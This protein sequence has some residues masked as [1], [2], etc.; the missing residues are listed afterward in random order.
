LF[1]SLVFICIPLISTA[2]AQVS[3]GLVIFTAVDETGVIIPGVQITVTEPGANAVE[4]WTDFAGRCTYRIL[5]RS[6]YRIHAEKAG[7][8]QAD[9]SNI[10]PA[11]SVVRITLAHQQVVREQVDVVASPP[12]IDP[13]Q[14][15]NTMT[16][17]TPEIVNIPYPTSRDIRNLLP[18][19]PGVVQDETGQVHV[20]GSE[21]WQTLDT[22]DGFDIR[23]PVSG[24]LALRVSSDAVRAIDQMSTRYPVEFGRSTGGVV[25]FYTGMGDNKFRFNATNFIPSFRNI[26]GI[27]FDKFVP[28]FT[29]SG[30]I[31]R[32]RVWWYDGLELEYSNI[33]IHELPKGEN[34]N[35]LSRG[36]N[37]VKV[38]ANLKPDN[39]L[40][41][42]YLFNA[43]RSP[44]DGIS[45][46]VPRVSTTKR[47][48]VAWL[49]Y[50][51][52]QWSFHRGSLLDV[53]VDEVRI[54]D[55]YMPR[56]NTPYQITPEISKGSYF[57]NLAGHSARQETTAAL[58]LSP[59]YLAGQ[60]DLRIGVDVDRVSFE[61]KLSRAPVSYLR[62]DGTLIRQSTFAAV[63]PY[64]LHNDEVGAYLQDR[65]KPRNNWLFEPGLRFDWDSLV[66]R[67]L[68]APRLAAIWTPQ[69]GSST[70]VSAGIGIYYD[71]TQLQYL[72]QSLTGARSDTYYAMNGLTPLGPAQQ[73]SFTADR[74]TLQDP[75]AVNWSVAIERK[76]P[77]SLFGGAS[78]IQKQ[79]SHQFTYV[80]QSGPVVFSG[81]Y[82]LANLSL[83][84]YH[85][86]QFNLRRVFADGYSLFFAY[87]HSSAMTNAALQY[88]PTPSPLGPQQSGPLP[89]DVPNR[90]I[91]WG[92]LP[93][94]LPFLKKSWDFVY[95]L[96]W[97]SGMPY[98]AVDA[99]QHVVGSAGA[100]R[101]PTTIDFSPGVEWRFHFWG[102]YYGLRGVME[103]ALDR[104]NPLVVNNVVDSPAFGTFS[105]PEGRAFTARI[106]IIASK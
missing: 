15:P 98:T 91:S 51:R 30:P 56:G 70:K 37:L 42:G 92:W 62:E 67:P 89:W 2:K 58:Y 10:E 40:K 79:T 21:T 5:G 87:T 8:Y 68:F 35:Q 43:L 96:D 39:I 88:W 60:H 54:R 65:W 24:M 32:D 57:E 36:S 84:G 77:W 71:H 93:L 16:M 18:F 47:D 6:P 104:P 27:R 13:E 44:Y 19:T 53:G 69:G 25:A 61:Q 50:V 11:E 95:T 3:S 72:A 94:D 4:L 64:S 1:V 7:F 76:L 97:H 52:D 99:A 46:L 101:F 80:N 75:R 59:R 83:D 28:R 49:A 103:N 9:E 33:Y 23:S 12:G 66:R 100:Y 31:K 63:S 85:A 73:S 20:S 26:D 106:R 90:A 14:V 105:E 102:T 17:N 86:A 78:Y 22:L 34:T 38:Q 29:F 55:G 45:P 41:A 48:T 81:N 74:T 82:Q